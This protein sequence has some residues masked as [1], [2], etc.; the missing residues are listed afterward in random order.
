MRRARARQELAKDLFFILIGVAI[1]IVLSGSGFI[2]SLIAYLGGHNIASFVSGIFFTSAFTLAPSTIAFAHISLS[3]PL[4]ETALWGGLGAMLGDLA[5]FLFI[6]DKFSEDLK[7]AFKPSFVHHIAS[8]FHFGFIKWLSPLIGAI[9]I[10]SP[11]PDEFGLALMGMSRTKL[12]VLMP[13]AFVMN[14]LG[15]YL[16]ATFASVL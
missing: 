2:D 1:A 6:R 11:L 15:I 7:G 10:A 8:S 13:V 5:L 3:S 9:I 14:V 4:L 12:Y 16:V